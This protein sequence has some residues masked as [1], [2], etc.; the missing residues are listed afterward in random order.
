MKNNEEFSIHGNLRFHLDN[1]TDSTQNKRANIG[2]F[3]DLK[4]WIND[5]D[6]GNI[7]QFHEVFICF[8]KDDISSANC[9]IRIVD[10]NGMGHGLFEHEVLL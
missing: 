5:V 2:I 10:E 6:N 1:Q 3:N 7:V 8:A 4:Y 9:N